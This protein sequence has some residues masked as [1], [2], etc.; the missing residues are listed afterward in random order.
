M[1]LSVHGHSVITDRVGCNSQVPVEKVVFMSEN[2]RSAMSKGGGRMINGFWLC[3]YQFVDVLFLPSLGEH[4]P[5]HFHRDQNDYVRAWLHRHRRSYSKAAKLFADM[6][7]SLR[8]GD[9]RPN[10]R[11]IP[12][13]VGLQE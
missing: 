13:K 4:F 2:A 5:V 1:Y 6:E 12:R 3:A 10:Y 8:Y 7:S 9:F 11:T